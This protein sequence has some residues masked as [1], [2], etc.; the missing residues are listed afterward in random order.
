MP[1]DQA[2]VVVGASLAGAKAAE[3]ARAHGFDGRVVLVGD[4]PAPPYERPPLSKAVLRGEAAPESARVHDSDFYESNGIEL[5]SGRTVEA[6]DLD[7]NEVRPRRWR[8]AFASPPSC[9][10]PGRRP[11]AST[12]PEP[13]SPACT[14]SVRST[15]RCGWL[16]RSAPLVGSP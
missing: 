7:G 16:R 9:W 6:L 11:D 14:T 5:L 13:S 8:D 3:S 15:T 2:L 10:R 12:S 4:E 1:T